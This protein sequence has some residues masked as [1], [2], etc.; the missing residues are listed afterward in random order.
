MVNRIAKYAV[1][2]IRPSSGLAT[3]TKGP[4]ALLITILVVI[5]Y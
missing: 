3:L 4:V 2:L 5:V 1:L